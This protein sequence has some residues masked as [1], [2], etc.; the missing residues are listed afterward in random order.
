MAWHA[1]MHGPLNTR[2]VTS[3]ETLIIFFGMLAAVWFPHV[4]RGIITRARYWHRARTGYIAR[5]QG[6]RMACD[7]PAE[8]L[9]LFEHALRAHTRR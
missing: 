6:A 2:G 1:R 7:T 4:C 5:E 3:M 9:A 8:K